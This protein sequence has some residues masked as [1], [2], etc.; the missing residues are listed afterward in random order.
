MKAKLI[1]SI[2]GLIKYETEF[3]LPEY[4]NLN[5]QDRTELRKLFIT[6]QVL[7]MKERYYKQI[8]KQKNYCI[9]MQVESKIKDIEINL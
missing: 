7:I 6:R 5:F 8:L 9:F 1:L 2:V 3:F 4:S